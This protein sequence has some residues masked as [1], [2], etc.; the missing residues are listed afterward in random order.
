MKGWGSATAYLLIG[1]V[2]A[3][4]M[5]PP[6]HSFSHRIGAIDVPKDWRRMHTE[7]IPRG[8]GIALYFACAIPIATT[9][10]EDAFLLSAIFGGFIMLLV[11]LADDIFHL[12][13]GSKLFLQT[14]AVSASLLGGGATGGVAFPLA[15]V[16]LLTLINA[17]NFIDG[18]DGL[19]SGSAGIEASALAILLVL[20]KDVAGGSAAA[21]V[22][23]ACF[24]FR[25]FNRYPATIFAGDCGSE[26]AG[27]LLG[28]LSLR[29]LEWGRGVWE[30]VP[31]LLLFG[32]P[33]TDL[34]TAVLR[35]I[36]RGGSPFAADR[37]HLHHRLF[38]TGLTQ[39][40]CVNILLSV[41]GM[42]CVCGVLSYLPAI[43]SL[44]AVS[45]AGGA[46]YLEG[47]RRYVLKK[48]ILY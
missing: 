43:R 1:Y 41:S 33:L 39:R 2:L 29:L 17:H 34:L 38:A 36:L 5:T 3:L 35:R 42:L 20:S 45:C 31:V 27:F 37:G 11:G 22:A 7:S 40:Q 16:W 10:R 48:A 44:A 46:L 8:G 47:M 32:Y 9:M 12:G 30:V 24:G 13:A 28:L 21:A 14:V 26:C 19:F 18:M 6:A 15:A 25:V 23:G 4:A